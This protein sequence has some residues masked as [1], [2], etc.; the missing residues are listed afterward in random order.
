MSRIV[1]DTLEQLAALCAALSR[2]GIAFTANAGTLTI[3]ITG[4]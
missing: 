3:T 1:A 2:E 4:W